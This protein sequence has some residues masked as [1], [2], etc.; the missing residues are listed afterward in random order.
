MLFFSSIVRRTVPSCSR[1]TRFSGAGRSSP[2]SQ[3]STAWWAM[4]SNGAS[5]D[6]L[7]ARPG[8]PAA[9]LLGVGLAEHLD[10]AQREL[11]VVGTGVP[12]VDGQRL[13]ELGGVRLLRDRHQRQVVVPHVVP[14]H[15]VRA[16]G[17]PVRV[18]VVGRA[19]QQQR[20]VQRTAGH[21]D[22]VGGQG[23]GAAVAQRGD[24][25]GDGPARRVGLQP[26]DVGVGEQLDV[27]VLERRVDA[28][29]LGVGLGPD[30]AGEAV[31]PVAPDA[32]TGPGRPA[33]GV[34]DEVDA[35][36]QVERVQALLLEVVAELLDARLVPD[37]RERIRGAGRALGGV[38]AVLAVHP[39]EVLGLGVERLQVLVADRP[40][41][42]QPAV[43][44]DLAEVLRPE[45]EQRRAVELGVA[46]DVVVQ[47]GRELVAVPVLPEL[48]R[49]VLPAHEHR[50]GVPVV[51]LP[52]QVVAAFQDQDALAR[53]GQPVGES[54]SAG[55]RADHDHVVVLVPC[56]RSKLVLG[57]GCIIT[58]SG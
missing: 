31:D 23:D 56:H 21:H 45:P 18:L 50:R 41:G 27:V 2:H 16:V 5:G 58:R 17:Q 49:P 54:P 38:L 6:S 33:V 15:D 7:L 4:T 10:A 14:A 39:V 44:P 47:L 52:R 46:S 55:S 34:L 20:R 48:R 1:V 24:D 57:E 9:H 43:V 25:P 12:V 53:P 37:R 11:P 36:R 35:D 3:K 22:D 13:L 32:R 28:D 29:D 42:R 26:L 40:R 51:P 8:C 30:Q 19:Q